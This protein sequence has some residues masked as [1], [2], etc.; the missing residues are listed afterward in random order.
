MRGRHDKYRHRTRPHPSPNRLSSV[1]YRKTP[2]PTER[3]KFLPALVRP[4]VAHF[5][6]DD[7]ARAT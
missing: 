4:V 5:V 3:N 1:V 2:A 6:H 7:L